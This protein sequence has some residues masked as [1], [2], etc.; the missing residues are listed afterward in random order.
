MEVHIG[1]GKPF[2][3]GA[4]RTA[5]QLVQLI[6]KLRWI[7]MDEE[8]EGVSVQLTCCRLRP[9]ETVLVGPWATD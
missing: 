4:Q 5:N 2:D 6:R 1:Q 3:I 7:G 8:A 9:T